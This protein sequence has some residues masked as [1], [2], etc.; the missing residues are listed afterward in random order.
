MLRVSTAFTGHV[1]VI[2]I[3]LEIFHDWSKIF[4]LFPI[5]R[6]LIEGRDP[7]A[8]S[9]AR[10]ALGRPAGFHGLNCKLFI[11]N[12]LGERSAHFRRGHSI[13]RLS[14]PALGMS[15]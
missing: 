1:P 2:G 14:R 12:C 8:N 7:A 3:F 10:V 9:R 11:I 15:R 4:P 5:A 6:T 13:P